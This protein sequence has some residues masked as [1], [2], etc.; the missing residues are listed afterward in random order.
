MSD[1]NININFPNSDGKDN[2]NS[3]YQQNNQQNNQQNINQNIKALFT[4]I[5]LGSGSSTQY[6]NNIL[7]K[8]TTSIDKLINK[9]DDLGTKKEKEPQEDKNKWDGVGK[10]IGLSIASVI[11]NSLKRFLASLMTNKF[12]FQKPKDWE[13]PFED[14]MSKL[15]NNY[16]DEKYNIRITN[17]IYAM[18]T[19]N[20]TN[21]CDGMWTNF[22]QKTGVL[23]HIKVKKLL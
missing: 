1:H 18:S 19:I 15:V 4:Q 7:Q 8:L 11:G 12:T 13:D 22:A 16:N 23:I 3:F 2:N 6:L 14:F 17:N 20:K 10:I 5:N 9:I 21:E